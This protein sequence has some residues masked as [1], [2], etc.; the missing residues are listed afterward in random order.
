MLTKMSNGDVWVGTR[1]GGLYVYDKNL[2][3]KEDKK[4]YPSNIYA[5]I[6]DAEGNVWYGSRGRG[7]LIKEKCLSVVTTVRL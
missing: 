6:E 7:L 3:L 4:Y 2:K 1:Q 5:A